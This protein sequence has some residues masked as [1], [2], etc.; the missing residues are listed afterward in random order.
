MSKVLSSESFS[1]GALVLALAQALALWWLHQSIE[2]RVW[3]ATEPG[4]LFAAYL[5]TVFLPL[6]LLVLWSRRHDRALWIAAG[7]L[8]A[9]LSLSGYQSFGDL[10]SFPQELN[11]DEDRI[12]GFLLPWIV[13]WLV[14][15]PMLRARLETGY[16]RT[17][18]AVL[19]RSAWRSYLTLAESALFTG[20][21]WLLLLLWAALFETLGNDFFKTL[22]SDPRFVYPATTLAFAAATQIIGSSDRFIDGVLDQLLGLMKWLLPLAGLIVIAFSIALLP[23]L[24]ALISSGERIINSAILLALVAATLLLFNAAYRE[25]DLDPGYGRWL[26]QVLRLVPPLLVLIALTALYSM[27]IRLI[28]L[29]F[30]PSRYWGLVTAVFAVLYSMGY[31]Y[32][33]FRSGPWLGAIKQVNF[34]VSLVLL[35]TLLASLT[36]IADP[37]RLSVVSQLNRALASSTAES[38]ASAL[39]FLRFDAGERGRSALNALARGDVIADDSARAVAL[40]D[41]AKR[42]AR[43]KSKKLSPKSDPSVTPAR[44]AEWRSRLQIVPAEMSVSPSL[45]EAIQLEFS[46]TASVL[47]P[48][49][50]APPP[51]IVFLDLDGDATPEAILLAGTL[52]G[53]PQHVRDYRVFRNSEG[54]WSRWSRGELR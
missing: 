11:L 14:G 13:A 50:N 46:F 44:Y 48:G 2:S 34:G 21:F 27:S 19:F 23:K 26:Q 51:L 12:A 33:S 45:E 22:F 15:V 29:G 18:Y 6:T 24:P 54:A 38:T 40:R 49:G 16:W 17:P 35:A 9:F 10:R 42:V 36:P 41:E 32:A 4:A 28:D 52:R 5:V 39:R 7:A 47:D 43:L 20:V 8:G 31:A 3:P 1:R 53:T 30:T 25:G 37:L